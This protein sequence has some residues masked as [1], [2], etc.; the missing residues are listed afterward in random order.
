M[1]LATLLGVKVDAT[2]VILVGVPEETI[3]MDSDDQPYYVAKL[4]NPVTVRCS[5]DPEILPHEADEVFIRKS[6]ITQEGWVFVDEKKP[7]EG[8]FMP[9]WVVDFSKGQNLPLYQETS[10]KKW[11]KTTRGERRDTTREKIN[12]G[13]REKL[14]AKAKG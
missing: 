12:T 5:I 13:I 3:Y 1:N 8:F 10:I 14:A 2:Q 9:N 4:K 7:A 6:A 11:T